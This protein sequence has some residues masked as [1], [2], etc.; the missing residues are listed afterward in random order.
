MT[1]VLDSALANAAGLPRG[2]P[3]ATLRL[4]SPRGADRVWTLRLGEETGEWAAGRPD[5]APARAA[6]PDPWL[7]WVAADGV[8]FGR[9]YRAVHRLQSPPRANLLEV[10]LRPDLP[11]EVA[12]TLFHLE[13]RP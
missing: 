8:F 1:V 5:L 7:S 12:L 10:A 4:K 2:T 3:V 6:S 9:R 13:I 11:P